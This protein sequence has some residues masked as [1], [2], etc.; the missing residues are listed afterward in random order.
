M[1]C[2]G[3]QV[4]VLPIAYAPSEVVCFRL[5]ECSVVAFDWL[6]KGGKKEGGKGDQT[7]ITMH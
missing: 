6:R 5:F 4:I 2:D 7:N 1:L 3:S